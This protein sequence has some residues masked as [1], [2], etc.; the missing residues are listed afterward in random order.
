MY[1]P[2]TLFETVG[3]FNDNNADDMQCGDMGEQ[4]LLSLGLKDISARVDPYQLIR[5]DL[6]YKHQLDGLLNSI[7]PGVKISHEE[8]VDILFAEMKEYSQMFSFQGKYKTLIGEMIEHFRYGNGTSFYSEKLNSAFHERIRTH[9][10][11]NPLSIIENNLK[12]EFALNGGEGDFPQIMHSIEK[13]LLDS[14][15]PKFDNKLDRINGLGI[16]VH[17][18][19]AQK[20]TI[21]HI[22]KYNQGWSATVWFDAQDHFGLDI[23]DI[24][25]KL[26]K[27]FRFFRIWFFLQRHKDFAFKPFFTNFH[28]VETI[29]SYW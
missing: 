10:L 23:N 25:N 20:I 29:G 18:I 22:Q 8:C 19:S 13:S 26:F 4:E 24:Q 14:R 17:D 15:L 7:T 6:P 11:D 21:S 12:D 9:S 27:E 5:Y 3:R 28:T 2:Y 1:L 16:T